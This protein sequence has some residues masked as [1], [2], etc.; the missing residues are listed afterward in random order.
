MDTRTMIDFIKASLPEFI[1]IKMNKEII[2]DIV[3]LINK[4]GKY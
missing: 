1:L 3:G 4:V 2:E